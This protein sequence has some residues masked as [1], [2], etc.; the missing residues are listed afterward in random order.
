MSKN[1]T[2]VAEYDYY[3]LEQ[4]RKIIFMEQKQKRKEVIECYI[5]AAI[6]FAIPLLFLIDWLIFGY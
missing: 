4:A 1:N 2:V 3:T 5:S 6:M